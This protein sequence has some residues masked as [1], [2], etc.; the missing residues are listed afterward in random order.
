MVEAGD[1]YCMSGC[2]DLLFHVVEHRFTLPQIKSLLAARRLSFLGFDLDP[3]LIEQFQKQFPSAAALT[4]LDKWHVFE[5]AN[6]QTFR[7]MYVFTVRKNEL[8]ATS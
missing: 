2:R 8:N 5:T 7:N 6:P 3:R 4:E 1:F